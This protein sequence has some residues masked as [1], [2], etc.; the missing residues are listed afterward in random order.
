MNK[1]HDYIFLEARIKGCKTVEDTYAVFLELSDYLGAY[2][3]TQRV[4]RKI[5]D[6]CM[7]KYKELK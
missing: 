7:D 4:Y 2:K 3:V 6:E 5:F 1:Q